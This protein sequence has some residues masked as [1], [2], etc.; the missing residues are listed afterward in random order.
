MI[1]NYKLNIEKYKSLNPISNVKHV[2]S[3]RIMSWN[4]RFWTDC[5]NAMSIKNQVDT[6]IAYQPDIVC[7]QE[8]TFGNNYYYKNNDEII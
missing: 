5:T 4:V 7:L 1:N 6:I 3:I 2:N 8:L